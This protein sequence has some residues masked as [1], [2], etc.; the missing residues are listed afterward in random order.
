[1][2]SPSSPIV[3]LRLIGWRLVRSSSSIWSG[4]LVQLDG[5]LLGRGLAAQPL[6]HVALDARQL[7]E[8]LEHVDGQADGAGRVGEARAGWPGGST[9]WRR[10]RTCSPWCSRTSPPRGSGRGCPPGRRRAGP[11]RGRCTSWRPRRPG[12][13]WPPACG[14]WRGWPSSATHSR[15]SRAA[16]D[17]PGWAL[18]LVLGVQAGLDALGQ[19]DLLGGGEQGAAADRLEVGVHRVAHDGR[20]VVQ[21][22]VGSASTSTLLG[23]GPLL[24]VDLRARR[25]WGSWA[26]SRPWWSSSS[27]RARPWS[28][29]SAVLRVGGLGGGLLR[30]GL[31]SAGSFSAARLT[32]ASVSSRRI[33]RP[34]AGLMP[35]L[36]EGVAQL[37][38]RKVTLDSPSVKEL[39]EGRR[40]LRVGSP[41]R[42][43]A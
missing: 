30:G 8:H 39:L 24:V 29:A 34:S 20:L 26:S 42:F 21:V 32:P 16:A 1:M 40:G 19:L 36:G 7:G 9:T 14:P 13:G 25:P 18:Q 6:V 37:R 3:A 11:C 28:C 10:W 31:A 2:V 23:G 12:G 4:R 17:R 35:G 27:S 22:E 5:Q 43:G 15:S 38:E 33:D 41:R